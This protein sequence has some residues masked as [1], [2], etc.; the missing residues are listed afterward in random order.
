MQD[1]TPQT[2][3]GDDTTRRIMD[4]AAEVFS[5][6]GY[7][8][9]RVDAIAKKANV[10]K[11]MIYYHIGDKKTL[12][13]RVLHEHFGQAANRMREL[14]K[15][16]QTPE[17]KIKTYIHYISQ[18]MDENPSKAAIMMREMA[19]GGRSLPDVVV[20]DIATII[21]SVVQI[22]D[23]G[24]SQNRFHPVNPMCVHLMVIGALMCHKASRPIRQK[25]PHIA[26][27]MDPM[28]AMDHGD[29]VNCIETLILRSLTK[30]NT[31]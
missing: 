6:V 8:G 20:E 9:A 19:G 30:Q 12:Y 7:A 21:G 1:T 18:V 27:A 28:A 17:E 16:A 4:T 22:I 25:L 5:E 10:N 13:T 31:A 29:F 11:A 14:L 26:D 2:S 3:R 15:Q 23:E 24:I